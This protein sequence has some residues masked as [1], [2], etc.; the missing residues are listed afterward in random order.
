MSKCLSYA[1]T[2]IQHPA[3]KQRGQS[4]YLFQTYMYSGP[5]VC[6]FLNWEVNLTPF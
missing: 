5:Y 3:C 4:T 6:L 1:R 2:R